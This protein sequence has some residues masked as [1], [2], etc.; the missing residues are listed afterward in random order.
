MSIRSRLFS[1]LAA[2][3]LALGG[4]GGTSE[5]VVGVVLPFTGEA[6]P[7]GEHLREGINLAVEDVNAAAQAILRFER[8]VTGVLLPSDGETLPPDI[9]P[10]S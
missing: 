7:Y 6:A 4:C 9:D 5:P 10:S 2:A 1:L 3:T 8:S